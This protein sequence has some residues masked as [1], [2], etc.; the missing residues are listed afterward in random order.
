M[1]IGLIK[2]LTITTWV[3]FGFATLVSFPLEFKG[4]DFACIIITFISA[5]STS[6][7]Y[8]QMKKK[9]INEDKN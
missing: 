8:F 1:N 4:L 5:I 7:G 6:F 3:C 2:I 9:K